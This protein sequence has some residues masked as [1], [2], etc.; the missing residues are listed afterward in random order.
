MT[1]KHI[2][3]QAVAA[4]ALM[5]ALSATSQAQVTP[6]S[7][8]DILPG[9][10]QSQQNTYTHESGLCMGLV[11]GIIYSH[12]NVCTPETVTL[13]QSVAVVVR[14]LDQNPSM[15]HEYFPKLASTALRAAWPCP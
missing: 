10:R 4:V 5:L 12:P 14:Y 13:R 2:A 3:K 9:C 8:N 1:A 15:W 7:A 11:R 6:F